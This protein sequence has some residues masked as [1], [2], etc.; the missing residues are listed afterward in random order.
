M[1]QYWKKCAHQIEIINY[2]SERKLSIASTRMH[3]YANY[4]R[5]WFES[6]QLDLL[7]AL[8]S[9]SVNNS[10]ERKKSLRPS[11]ENV[12]LKAYKHFNFYFISLKIDGFISR[13]NVCL[14][15]IANAKQRNFLLWMVIASE[16]FNN[17]RSTCLFK[18]FKPL[19]MDSLH[20]G[21]CPALMRT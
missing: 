20:I 6:I 8:Q 2:F 18:H 14:F 15:Y 7:R 9:T 13:S 17:H 19:I 11:A 21:K 1:I 10:M 5:N 12:R 4:Y 3:S 16:C